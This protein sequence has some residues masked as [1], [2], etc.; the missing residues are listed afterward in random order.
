M[1]TSKWLLDYYFIYF[2]FIVV[3]SKLTEYEN[4]INTKTSIKSFKVYLH[5][6][7]NDYV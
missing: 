6:T 4:K 7:V 1:Q 5:T 3:K 2:C